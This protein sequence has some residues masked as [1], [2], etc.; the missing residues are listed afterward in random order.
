SPVDAVIVE[1]LLAPGEYVYE[2]TPLLHLAKTDQLN[3]EVLM[4]TSVYGRVHEGMT[5]IVV[6]EPPLEGK[7]EATV[8]VIDKIMDAASSSFGVQLLLEN[9]DLQIPAGLRCTL[10]IDI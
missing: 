1:R 7:Y 5:A 2:Q 4:P 8:E 10:E 6:P 3:V 9:P